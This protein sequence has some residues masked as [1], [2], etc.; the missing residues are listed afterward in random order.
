MD[1]CTYHVIQ[2]TNA[3]IVR[4]TE[5]K[6]LILY[7]RNVLEKAATSTIAFFGFRAWLFATVEIIPALTINSSAINTKVDRLLPWIQNKLAK[8]FSSK[9]CNFSYFCSFVCA[10]LNN[11]S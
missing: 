5:R 8:I 2:T 4:S 11:R 1:K 6:L 3:M 10:K 7:A 9:R